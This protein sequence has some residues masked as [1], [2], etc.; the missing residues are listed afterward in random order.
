VRWNYGRNVFERHGVKVARA[1]SS[2]EEYTFR[3]VSIKRKAIDAEPLLELVMTALRLGE[4][5][6]ESVRC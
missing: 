4:I 2:A 1:L 5:I 6:V 3:F